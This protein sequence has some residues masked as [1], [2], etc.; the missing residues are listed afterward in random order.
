[1]S[2]WV[3]L[4]LAAVLQAG[5]SG[6][7]SGCPPCPQS[8]TCIQGGTCALS[9]TPDAGA[10][11]PAGETCRQTCGNCTVPYCTCALAWVCQP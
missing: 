5:C 11:C 10:A 2:K 4:M 8:E 9:C 3:A 1:M 6:S 7:N